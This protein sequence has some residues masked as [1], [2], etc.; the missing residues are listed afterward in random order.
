MYIIGVSPVVGRDDKAAQPGWLYWAGER[1]G[2]RR[3]HAP[4]D[5]AGG[6]IGLV[7]S[8]MAA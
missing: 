8:S 2:R 4:D 7:W 5:F 3:R 6:L 1:V